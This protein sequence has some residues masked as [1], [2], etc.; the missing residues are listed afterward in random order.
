[1]STEQRLQRLEDIEAIKQLIARYATAADHNGDPE[2]MAPLFTADAVWN[3]EGIG[4]F[5]TRDG[6]AQGL[7]QVSTE[8]I[9]WALHYMTQPIIE[10]AADGKS[11]NGEYYLWELAKV[12]P[13]DGGPAQDTWIGGWYESKFRKEGDSWLFAHIELILKLLSGTDKPSWETPIPPWK[14]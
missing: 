7:R 11:A 14:P 5:E 13:E 8:G 2:M 12:M 1:M 3:C 6:I 4:R 9:S 10:I